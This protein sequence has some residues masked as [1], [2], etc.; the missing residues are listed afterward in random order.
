MFLKF[1]V[2]NMYNQIIFLIP[3]KLKFFFKYS[4]NKTL[5]S[6]KKRRKFHSVFVFKNKTVV[7]IKGSRIL[8]RKHLK[9][10]LY[11]RKAE[12]EKKER[13]TAVFS[14]WIIA[15]LT[16]VALKLHQKATKSLS[17]FFPSSLFLSL[18]LSLSLFLGFPLFSFWLSFSLFFSFPLPF[19]LLFFH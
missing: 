11:E 12:F 3:L 9:I 2:L 16:F 15:A 8:Q 1:L 13:K 14:F 18:S 5:Y 7:H 19:S 17:Q 6:L 10:L 4:L